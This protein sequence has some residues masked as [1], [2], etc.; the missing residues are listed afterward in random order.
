[1]KNARDSHLD[2]LGITSRNFLPLNPM[3]FTNPPIE[4]I[5]DFWLLPAFVTTTRLVVD[6]EKIATQSPFRFMQVARG[7]YM[8]VAMTNC[9]D[10]GWTSSSSGYRYDDMDR[11]GLVPKA[12]PPMPQSFKQIAKDSAQTVGWEYVAPDACLV[13]RYENGAG[14]GLHQDKDENDLNNPIVSVSIGAS[15][16]FIIG[17]LTRQSP[18]QSITLNDGDVFIWGKKA[19]LVFHGVRP[20]KEGPCR[21]NLTMRKAN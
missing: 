4:V 7:S 19:R 12:W 21:Y 10:Y 11:Q 18:T 9:G 5:P 6:I 17:G 14:M 1:V 16:K 2:T 3:L 20:I 8:K 15:C 13:N